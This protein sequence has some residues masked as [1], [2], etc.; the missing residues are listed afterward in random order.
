MIEIIEKVIITLD[1]YSE[2][3]DD[4]IE[5]FTCPKCDNNLIFRGCNFCPECG[6]PLDLSGITKKPAWKL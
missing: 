4:L 6:V 2:T 1:M 5:W 3:Q